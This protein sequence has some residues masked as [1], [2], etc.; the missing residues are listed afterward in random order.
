MMYTQEE[1]LNVAIKDQ[2][3]VNGCSRELPQSI[4]IG[5]KLKKLN[6]AW[7]NSYSTLPFH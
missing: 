5:I 2:E 1:E 3:K 6:F 4:H 7:N